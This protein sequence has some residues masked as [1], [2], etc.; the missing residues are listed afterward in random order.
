MHILLG[1]ER[2]GQRE[3]CCSERVSAGAK[4][5]T[6]SAEELNEQV[7]RFKIR[8]EILMG[9]GKKLYECKC[10]TQNLQSDNGDS[11]SMYRGLHGICAL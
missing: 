9:D 1:W 6:S 11:V 3:K 2:I 8:E 7:V 10:D 4:E 5:L